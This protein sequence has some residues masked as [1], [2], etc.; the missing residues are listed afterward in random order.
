M[1]CVVDERIVL[2]WMIVEWM[3]MEIGVGKEQVRLFDCSWEYGISVL[4]A[5]A[6]G[7][8]GSGKGGN[9]NLKMCRNPE[10]WNA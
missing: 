10:Y 9:R 2:P 4:K 8:D 6:K 5:H 3:Q 1:R 7:I